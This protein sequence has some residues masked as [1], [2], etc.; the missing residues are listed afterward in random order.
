MGIHAH[1]GFCEVARERCAQCD[2]ETILIVA[3]DEWKVSGDS[4]EKDDKLPDAVSVDA[5]LSAHYCQDCRKIV[6][7]SF[8]Q[9]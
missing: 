1:F 8:N 9:R 2:S 5:E 7:L 4:R 3:F 6:S